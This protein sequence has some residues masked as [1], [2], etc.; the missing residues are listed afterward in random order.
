MEHEGFILEDMA[1]EKGTVWGLGE[2]LLEVL[3]STYFF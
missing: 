3:A 2:H 1:L